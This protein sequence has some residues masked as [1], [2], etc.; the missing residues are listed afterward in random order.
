MKSFKFLLP[1]YRFLE[2][3]HSYLPVISVTLYINVAYRHH[4]YLL[5][6]THNADETAVVTFKSVLPFSLCL[7][8]I[9]VRKCRPVENAITH[10]FDFLHL[11]LSTYLFSNFFY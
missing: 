4:I 5:V 8:L 7:G 11:I 3:V 9:G 10:L 6:L 2:N 1:K